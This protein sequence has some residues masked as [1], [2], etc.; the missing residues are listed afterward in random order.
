MLETAGA[1]AAPLAALM[2]E[3]DPLRGAPA[4]LLLRLE[5]LRDGPRLSTQSRLADQ[6]GRFGTDQNRDKAP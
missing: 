4:D 3:R 6:H 1:A 2:A 5:A